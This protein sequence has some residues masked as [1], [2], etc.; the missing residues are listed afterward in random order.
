MLTKVTLPMALL[1]P[2]EP[3]PTISQSIAT[4]FVKLTKPHHHSQIK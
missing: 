4:A 1:L 3:T 2:S